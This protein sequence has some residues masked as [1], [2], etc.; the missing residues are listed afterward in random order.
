MSYP[1]QAQQRFCSTQRKGYLRPGVAA[2]K[3][4][5]ME[6]CSL[7]HG[8]WFIREDKKNPQE[9]FWGVVEKLKELDF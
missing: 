4:P 3:F 1:Q 5:M 9:L 8:A 2:N 6:H 7:E